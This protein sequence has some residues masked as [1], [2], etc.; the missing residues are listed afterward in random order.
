[1]LDKEKFLI[2]SEHGFLL[3]LEKG[4]ISRCPHYGGK[5]ECD[6]AEE[7]LFDLDQLPDGCPVKE[8]EELDTFCPIIWLITCYKEN[9]VSKDEMGAIMRGSVNLGDFEDTKEEVIRDEELFEK[10]LELEWKAEDLRS[11]EREIERKREQLD[12]YEENGNGSIDPQSLMKMEE[13]Y[14]QKIADLETMVE[15]LKEE[16]RELKEEMKDSSNGEKSIAE[17]EKKVSEKEDELS[18]WEEEITEKEK[19]LEEREGRI[20]E[21]E[22]DVKERS[23]KAKELLVLVKKKDAKVKKKIKELNR[24]RKKTTEK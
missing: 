12:D 24:L 15:M 17:R 5:Y 9:I 8:K 3:Q 21:M 6:L 10:K 2:V 16:N 4:G 13:E 23:D 11:K 14:S 20:D 19:E 7:R 1:M 18:H 22:E